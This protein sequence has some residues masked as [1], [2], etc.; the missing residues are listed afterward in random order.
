M[1]KNMK[2]DE[3]TDNIIEEMEAASVHLGHK[4]SKLHPKMGK[5]IVGIKNTVHIIDLKETKK[6]LEEALGFISELFKNGQK[7]IL[8]NSK[9]PLKNLIE[10]IA[11]EA[12]IPYVAERWLGG[13]LTNF[14]V[15]YKRIKYFKDLEKNLAEGKFDNLPKK[16]KLKIEKEVEKLKKK[17]EGIKNLEEIP[18]AIFICDLIKDKAAF[19]EARMKGIKTLAIVHTNVDPTMVDYPIPA[20]DDAISSVGYILKKVKETIIKST[21][22]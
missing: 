6:H 16:E 15:I 5:Y 14:K 9:P 8:I 2:K 10:E 4:I 3:E 17:F 19:K 13:T 22:S 12:G 18:P 20:N 11:K 1:G 21:K 7:I